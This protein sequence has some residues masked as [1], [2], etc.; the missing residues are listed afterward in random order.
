MDIDSGSDQDTG[1]SSQVSGVNPAGIT[2]GAWMGSNV[3]QYEIDW[4]YR[5]RRI[6]E[7]VI[8]RLPGDEIE[9]V[10]NP[11]EH[12]VFLAHFEH[13]FGLPASEF[14]RQFLDFYRLL[15]H[16]L[17]GNAVFYLSC[18]AT[19]MEAY[20][21]IRPTRKT[22]ARFFALW[23][24]SV[25]GKD[26]PK[27]KP[28][29]QCGSCIIGSR[30]GSPFFKFT[31]LESCRLWQGTFFYVRNSGAADHI[32]LPP[33]NPAPPRKINWSYNP[34]TDH[35]ETNRVVRFMKELIK[36]TSICSD[37]IIR[38]FISRRVLPLK[39]RVHKMSEMYGPG[40]PTKIT[41]LPL[42][43]KDI[44]LKA[45]QI[46]QTAMPD[47][48]EWGL[49]PLS[50]T[51]PPTQEAKDRFPRIDLDRRGPCRKRGLDKF[52]PDPFIR[53]QDLKMGRTPASRL[54]KSPPEPA[55]SSDDLTLLE[56]HE[57]VA[58][59]G[60]EAGHEF[61]E[62]LMA[63][64][65][66]N[67]APASD[68]GSSQAPASK[69]FRT[70]PVAGKI[71]GVRRYKS[72]QMPTSSGPALKLGPAGPARTS[73]PP[74]HSSPAPSGAGNTSASPLG[75]TAS[76]GHAAPTPP[77]HRA[78]EDPV[79]P[80]ENQNTG[81]SDIGAGEETAGRAEPLVPPVLEKKKKKKTKKSSPSKAAPEASAPASSNPGDAS[82][83]PPSPKTTPTPP[84]E[85]P[86]TEP[87]GTTSTAPA[88]NIL[89]LTKGKATAPSASSGGQQPLVLHVSRAASSAGEKA[90][91]LLGRITSFQREGRELGHLLPYAE[92][93]NAADMSKATRGLGKDR[94]PAPDPVGERS[95]EEHFMRLRRAV[96]ELDS[97]WFDA[98]NNLMT[99]ADA[100]KILFEELLWEHRDLAEA[101]S[102]CQAIPEASIEALKTQL[103]A[104]EE[105][106]D[107]LSLQHKEELSAQETCYGE[108]KRQYIQLGL[109]HAK[110]LQAAESTAE[111]KLHE[112]LEDAGNANVV[113]QAELE[114]AAKARKAAED[115]AARL[116]AEQKEY[117]LLVTQTD[118]LA[119][120]LFP[121]S[122]AFAVKR[123]GERR[124]AQAYKNLSAP[125]D[126]YDHLVALNARVSHMRAID[127][128]LSDIPDVATQLFRTLW[129]G[130]E[131]PDTF[132]LISDRLKGASRRI[133]EWQCS[134]ARARADSALRVACSW[135]PELDLDVFTGVREGAETDLDPVLAA[136]RQDRAYRIAEYAEMRTF[137]PPPADVKD[138]L[139]DEEEDED[140]DEAGAGDAPPGCSDANDAPSDAPVA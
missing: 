49:R 99:T 89:A 35:I 110:A 31:G 107:Q 33:F 51:N 30:Q 56:V 44:V 69:R 21:G 125:W 45:R 37:D 103:A 139:S 23:I 9:P 53:W 11:G 42:S 78:E 104:A 115:K 48:W 24:N 26:I 136:K 10:L 114:E 130:E 68:A 27:P 93:W 32:N 36:N 29:V 13:G 67:K 82:D 116:E 72:R 88:P 22:F 25:Q 127:R 55:G 7:S 12:V 62:K 52:D 138:Y 126:P 57:H 100:R 86:H 63:Q 38:A 85:A 81:A 3:S 2:R 109:D 19:F 119:L 106:K 46:C 122:R 28:P 43:K 70:E 132:S 84:P 137:I 73:T 39:C 91:G 96:K 1:S 76:S 80:L 95:S 6:P 113:L 123:V 118:A 140:A 117:D 60:A 92:K 111:A 98:T 64:G 4:L 58:P 8:C 16:H 134:A 90:T 34:K 121:D 124:V 77:D 41:G 71:T 94:L 15:P 50:S 14:F 131:V 120:R 65:Q 66:T 133:R 59:L 129:P 101:H 20:I 112:A 47:D 18:Y 108:L 128:N 40:D 105:K 17:P 87:A 61:V 74:P 75:G 135:Y 5:S 83:A 97:A 102:K 54:G 79:S